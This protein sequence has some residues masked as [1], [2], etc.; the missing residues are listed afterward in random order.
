MGAALV[1]CWSADKRDGQV[2]EEMSPYLYIK[3]H[4]HWQNLGYSQALR[5]EMLQISIDCSWFADICLTVTV[6]RSHS[7]VL[8]ELLQV[9]RG[10]KSTS[11]VGELWYQPPSTT[12]KLHIGPFFTTPTPSHFPQGV[13][14]D[15]LCSIF[16]KNKIQTHPDSLAHIQEEVMKS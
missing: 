10:Q 16:L 5:E 13:I 15:T 1:W 4:L 2:N 8:I 6:W 12:W 14:K 9:Q 11:S 7:L 3:L